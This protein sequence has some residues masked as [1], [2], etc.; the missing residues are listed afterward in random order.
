MKKKKNK[1]K[2]NIKMFLLFR[3]KHKKTIM[4]NK[5]VAKKN[6]L[7]ILEIAN[8]KTNQTKNQL[9]CFLLLF[10]LSLKKN[11]QLVYLLTF[12]TKRL[13]PKHF[14][15]TKLFFKFEKIQKI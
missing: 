9:F 1:I 6:Y 5:K 12:T 11:K 2:R 14:Q 10:H 13:I 4:S 15:I 8:E 7:L 3:K